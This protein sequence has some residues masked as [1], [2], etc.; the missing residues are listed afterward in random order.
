MSSPPLE[1]LIAWLR[2]QGAGRIEHSGRTLLDHLSNT[3]AILAECGQEPHV[4][5]AG[6][7][8]SAYGTNAFRRVTIAP[9]RRMEV[10]ELI[11]QDA[12]TL[13]WI[14]GHIDRPRAIIEALQRHG[15]EWPKG[16]HPRGGG[17][18]IHDLAAIE[19]ANLL[20]QHELW[21]VPALVP[22]AK[23]FGMLTDFGFSRKPSE[24]P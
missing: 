8:H 17:A 15:M 4:C 21:S 12:E 7:F 11:G 3:Y 16:E 10:R 24:T 9:S 14:F 19:C 13:A 1:G 5:L 22:A 23:R 2:M 20:E 18:A 6:L